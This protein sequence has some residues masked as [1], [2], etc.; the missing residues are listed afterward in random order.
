MRGCRDPRGLWPSAGR[1]TTAPAGTSPLLLPFFLSLL[2]LLLPAPT[3][4]E[5]FSITSFRSDIEVRDDASLRITETIE[6]VFHRK[7]H[8]LYRDI[9]FRYTDELGKESF[10][11]VRGI[12]VRDSS[13]NPWKHK[14]ERSGGFVRVRIGD[15]GRFVEGR[16]VYVI[17]YNVENAVLSFPD[18]DELYWNLTGNGWEVPIGSVSAHVAVAAGDRSL[19]LRTRCYTGPRGSRE[20]ACAASP[21]GN[22]A[23]FVSTRAF[24][25]REGMTVVLG[26]EKG[27][28][29]PASP[30]KTYAFRLN[31]SE[32]WVFLAPL[33]TL[34][35]M[36]VRWYREGRDPSASGPRVVAYGPPE[37]GGRP[38][39]PAE[40]GVL[41]DER[42]D[43]RDITAS[44]VDLAVKG[45]ITIEE[46]VTADL[47]F[48]RTDYV[49][50]KAKGPAAELPPFERLL[51]E[52]LYRGHGDEVSVSDLKQEFYRNIEDLKKSAF[53]ELERMKL[54]GANPLAVTKK[55][56][57]AGFAVLFL[58]VGIALL[59]S[60]IGLVEGN[61]PGIAAFLSGFVVFLFAPYMPVKTVKGMK[62]MGAI[63]GFEEF[64]SRTERD[65]LDLLADA[66]LFERC[67]PYAIALGV[68]ERWAKA[69]EGIE[70]EPP[71]WYVSRGGFDTFRPAAFHH[72]LDTA[73][74]SM[75]AAMQSSPRSGGSGFSGGGGSGGGGGGGGGGSW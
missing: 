16:Q 43:P 33:L 71:R 25:P 4:A 1:G 44:V 49:L 2:L 34:A 6:T 47:L 45:R 72:S 9:P 23:T 30:W 70:Q 56:R 15:P 40:L 68:S 57:M 35:Y 24:G 36:L 52:R 37:D 67:L 39:L 61:S 7:R 63:L 18:Y 21:S 65:R 75:A 51:M 3:R 60:K 22:G 31:L 12:S 59:A 5:D 66:N 69:F 32:N 10:T 48:D 13:G 20:Q 26:W 58:G 14:V 11:P 74:S 41:L 17:E 46:K 29:R 19:E 27:V 8:G 55:Y 73:L 64:L 28:V 62:T 38:L 42:L 53:E 54:F 50:R